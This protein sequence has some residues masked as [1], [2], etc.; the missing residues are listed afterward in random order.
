MVE[1]HPISPSDQARIHQFGK[2]VLLGL[3]LDSE[4]VAGRSWKRYILT[5]DLEDL[6]KLEAS[7]IYS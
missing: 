2:K 7:E 6:Q 1:Y 4:L 3:F 5:A